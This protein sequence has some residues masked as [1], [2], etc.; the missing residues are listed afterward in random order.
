M[1]QF[2]DMPYFTLE[3]RDRR[4]TRLRALMRAAG[5]DCLV[6]RSAASDPRQRVSR[7]LAQVGGGDFGTT[8]V[9][10]HNGEP[11]AFLTRNVEGEQAARTRTWITDLRF[12]DRPESVA[13]QL[14]Q[15]GLANARIGVIHDHQPPNSPDDLK[16]A[17]SKRLPAATFYSEQDLLRTA[18]L[19]KGPEE[20]ELVQ[21]VIVANEFAFGAMCSRARPGGSKEDMTQN[22]LGI[23]LRA[24][25]RQPAQLDLSFDGVEDPGMALVVPDRVPASCL[26]SPEIS[27]CIFGYQAESNHTILIG[28]APADYTQAMAATAEVFYE[29]LGWTRPGVTVRE[30]CEYFEVICRAKRLEPAASR[31]VH[32]NGLFDWPWVGPRTVGGA[33]GDVELQPGHTFTLRP[34]VRLAS[35]TSTQYGEP[36]TITA[37][38]ARR[39]S[40]HEPTPVN[41][42]SADL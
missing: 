32:T 3:E 9:F 19:V 4:W 15:L 36:I 28:D 27:A 35:G 11:A 6:A 38:G 8:V 18:H 37:N 29:V 5:C 16:D 13:E 24:S 1:E 21:L 14:R 22:M 25:G 20:I 41:I 12:G 23:L 17:L 34:T 7:Y 31:L 10:P 2:V 39:L 26:C 40:K 30:I 33:E 42:G